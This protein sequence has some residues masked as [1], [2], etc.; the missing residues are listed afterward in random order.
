MNGKA[1]IQG[2][3]KRTQGQVRHSTKSPWAPNI[4]SREV[5]KR[6]DPRACLTA[7]TDHLPGQRTGLIR[8]SR[9]R[10]HRKRRVKSVRMWRSAERYNTNDALELL[11]LQ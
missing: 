10:H 3:R 7:T 1:M 4:P 5:A 11:S 6:S 2:L 8:N 9:V